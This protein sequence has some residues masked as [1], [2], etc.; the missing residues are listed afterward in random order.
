MLEVRRIA[1][2]SLAELRAVV[3][4]YRSVDLAAELA[5]ARSLLASAG[6]CCAVYGDEAGLSPETHR[7]LGWVVREGT[8]NV[9]RHSEGRSCTITLGHSLPGSVRLTIDNDGVAG[10]PAA[11]TDRV[12]FGNGLVG[13]SERIAALGGTLTAGRHGVDRFSLTA[14]LPLAPA[15]DPDGGRAPTAAAGAADAPTTPPK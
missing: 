1:H 9:L 14:E 6:I 10:G 7:V 3:G 11:G 5:G 13:L 2:E 8:T 15:V 12:R 4:G